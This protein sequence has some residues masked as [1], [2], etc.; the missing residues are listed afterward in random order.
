MKTQEV[1]VRELLLS[2]RLVL[3]AEGREGGTNLVACLARE[4][5]MVL[6]HH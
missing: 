6:V 4:V 2:A 5:H 1:Y 3:V